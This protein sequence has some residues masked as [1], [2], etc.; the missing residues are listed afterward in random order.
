[1]NALMQALKPPNQT[2]TL[3]KNM[4]MIMLTTISTTEKGTTW[5]IW[6]VGELMGVAVWILKHA[7]DLFIDYLA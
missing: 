4:T 1:M 6:A 7:D 2:T 5:M 3:M